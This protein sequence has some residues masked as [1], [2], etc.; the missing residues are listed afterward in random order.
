[1]RLNQSETACHLSWC[2]FV[3][4]DPRFIQFALVYHNSGPE[5]AFTRHNREVFTQDKLGYFSNSKV[6][7]TNGTGKVFTM[8]RCSLIRGIHYETFHCTIYLLPEFNIQNAV[9]QFVMQGPWTTRRMLMPMTLMLSSWCV[10]IHLHQ[11]VMRNLPSCVVIWSIN[12]LRTCQRH[13][14][15]QWNCMGGC[16]H[17]LTLPNWS[18]LWMS[19]SSGLTTTAVLAIMDYSSH[20]SSWEAVMINDWQKLFLTEL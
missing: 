9:Y 5:K 7:G 1:M 13:S 11:D 18:V 17:S 3:H 14:R 16:F 10:S 15:N 19:I 20:Q 4:W 2:S 12:M 8:N 6:Y